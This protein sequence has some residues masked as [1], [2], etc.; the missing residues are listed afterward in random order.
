MG[1][2]AQGGP[3]LG[4]LTNTGDFFGSFVQ[5]GFGIGFLTRSEAGDRGLEDLCDPRPVGAEFDPLGR[6]QSIGCGLMH[7]TPTRVHLGV[8]E[9]R[10]VYRDHFAQIM[11]Q[12]DLA[13]E[14]R[15]SQLA[16]KLG[17]CILAVRTIGDAENPCVCIGR[18]IRTRDRREGGKA[19]LFRRQR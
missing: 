15:V 14:R 19:N 12:Q 3:P 1:Q 5:S 16:K 13:L 9:I 7:A 17:R 10:H 2:A 6:G 4:S 18:P 8:C 11:V